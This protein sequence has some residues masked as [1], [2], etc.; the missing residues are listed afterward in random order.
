MEASEWSRE[1]E[2]DG[3]VYRA[4]FIKRPFREGLEVLVTLPEQTISVADMGLGENA[5]L[6]RIRAILI[7]RSATSK[8][9]DPEDVDP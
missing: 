3:V 1:L 8:P 9:S 6:E 7:A 5:L 4:V 2:I